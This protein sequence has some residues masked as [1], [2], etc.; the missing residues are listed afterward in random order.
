MRDYPKPIKRKLRE[1]IGQSYEAELGQALTALAEKFEQWKQG[2]ITAGELSSLIHDFEMKTSRELYR[3]H[4]DNSML[5]LQ[6]A[7]AIVNGFIDKQNV[8][9]EVLV[10]LQNAIHFYES[11]DDQRSDL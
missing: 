9:D 3:R 8:P 5:E 4:N 10:V 6:V 11:M 2:S 1:L 7:Y